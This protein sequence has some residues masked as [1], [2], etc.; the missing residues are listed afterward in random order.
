LR[1]DGN[2]TNSDEQSKELKTQKHRARHGCKLN[3]GAFGSYLSPSIYFPNQWFS[4]DFFSFP[5]G[6]EKG[7]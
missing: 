5:L 4:F 2:N 1:P 3:P 6:E 7:I